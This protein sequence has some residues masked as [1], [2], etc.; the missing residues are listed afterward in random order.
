MAILSHSLHAADPADPLY[1]SRNLYPILQK[2]NCRGCHT[3][4]GVGS[5]TRVRF[6]E[7]PAGAQAVEAFGQSLFV[8]V[9]RQAPSQSALVLKPTNQ[10]SHAGGERIAKGSAEAAVL[11]AWANYLAKNPN[12]SAVSWN[13]ATGSSP[14][15]RRLTHSQYNHT[16]RDLLGDAT[17]PANQFPEEDFVDG[18]KNQVQ[19]QSISPM[20]AEAYVT[21]AEKLARNAFRFGDRNH[22][23]PCKPV[24]PADAK[25]AGQFIRQFGL[26]AYR[27]PLTASEES[28]LAAVFLKEAARSGQFQSG[29]RMTIETMLQ[30]PA[31]LF[32]MEREAAG[33]FEIAAR[34]SYA[35][36]DSM[37][38]AELFSSAAAGKLVIVEELEKQTRRMLRNPKARDSFDE[39]ISQWLRFDR[40]LAS[41]KDRRLYPSFSPSTLD[42]MLEE[43][44]RFLHHLVWENG[45]FMEALSAGYT[46]AN[47]ELTTLYGLPAPQAPFAMVRYPAASERAGLLGQGTFLAQTGK[48]EETSPTERG[49]FIRAHF[50]CQNVPPPPP[51]VNTTLKPFAIGAKPITNR[52]RLTKA[53]IANQTCAGCHALIDPIGFGLERFDTL[54]RWS[55]KQQVIV[56]PTKDQRFEVKPEKH[57]LELDT[58]ASVR[59]IPNSDFDSAKSLG[60]ILANDPTCQACIVRQW[61]RFAFG[62][63]DRQSDAADVER[64]AADFRRSGFHFQDLILSMVR[65]EVFRGTRERKT[66]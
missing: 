47:Q 20:L 40:L 26:R 38:D 48:S 63:R 1:F 22:L 33:S 15:A 2:A 27:R 17:Q 13:P 66:Q 55:L 31:F 61:F 36:W 34:L 56:F 59:G 16:V 35:L 51:G 62:R 53:H 4:E 29:A 21:A 11:L 8:L 57:E 64:M 45:N 3:Q 58:A 49:L 32:R 43:T 24:S 42:A 12:P 7:E 6:P 25:C 54:G 46:F 14:A 23:I 44:R 10:L 65:S 19:A 28:A 37:P 30:S 39:F 9:D 41:V 5:A 52:E 18:F 60:R 50:L